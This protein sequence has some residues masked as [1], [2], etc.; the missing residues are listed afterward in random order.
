VVQQF[1]KVLIG[2]HDDGIDPDWGKGV[3]IGGST[4]QTNCGTTQTQNYAVIMK[5]DESIIAFLIIF[6]DLSQGFCASN[7]CQECQTWFDFAKS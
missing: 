2:H 3:Q 7:R 1:V 5:H 4:N 6:R